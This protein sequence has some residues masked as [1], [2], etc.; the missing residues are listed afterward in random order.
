MLER[1]DGHAT[2]IVLPFSIQVNIAVMLVTEIQIEGTSL[3]AGLPRYDASVS[4]RLAAVRVTAAQLP[5][6]VQIAQSIHQRQRLPEMQRSLSEAFDKQEMDVVWPLHTRLQLDLERIDLQM[7]TDS[8]TLGW[9]MSRMKLEQK[10]DAGGQS[11]FSGGI[12]CIGLWCG[13]G[14][15]DKDDDLLLTGARDGEDVAVAL[16][17]T[18]LFEL[19]RNEFDR[20]A[21]VEF[22]C[23]CDVRVPRIRVVKP[24]LADARACADVLGNL[25]APHSHVLSNIHSP[26]P[27]SETVHAGL[28]TTEL[29]LPR[30]TVT[31]SM[32]SDGLQ[33]CEPA[34]EPNAKLLLLAVTSVHLSQ[35]STQRSVTYQWKAAGVSID[36]DLP[37]EHT[38]DAALP[39]TFLRCADDGITAQ[40]DCVAP[41]EGELVVENIAATVGGL[42]ILV[43]NRLILECFE[44]AEQWQAAVAAAPARTDA[45]AE[46]L[47][48]QRQRMDK[49]QPAEPPE[50]ETEPSAFAIP[51]LD[52]VF[53]EF[54]IVVPSTN[55]TCGLTLDAGDVR[56]SCGPS[57]DA[58][59]RGVV[60]VS[61]LHV[62]VTQ[63]TGTANLLEQSTTFSVSVAFTQ[64]PDRQPGVRGLKLATL[65]YNISAVDV[66]CSRSKAADIAA[67]VEFVAENEIVRRI[68]ANEKKVEFDVEVSCPS[69]SI[70][71]PDDTGGKALVLN[72][73]AARLA[74]DEPHG[75]TTAKVSTIEASCRVGGED[76]V[77]FLRLETVG[78]A[79]DAAV[80]RFVDGEAARLGV[81]L[82]HLEL[83]TSPELAQALLVPYKSSSDADELAQPDDNSPQG[84]DFVLTQDDII[85]ADMTV[86]PTQRLFVRAKPGEV[87]VLQGNGFS[88]RFDNTESCVLV[89]VSAGA[90]LMLSDTVLENWDPARVHLGAGARICGVV[91]MIDD[92]PAPSPRFVPTDLMSRIRTGS[93][94]VRERTPSPPPR[95]HDDKDPAP[96]AGSVATAAPGLI[97]VDLVLASCR[98]SF[99]ASSNRFDDPPSPATVRPGHQRA[100]SAD[101]G[102][103]AN[104]GV[105]RRRTSSDGGPGRVNTPP[106]GHR[107]TPSNVR[108]SYS[109][110][111]CARLKLSLK[112]Q[113][114]GGTLSAFCDGCSFSVSS[115][116]DGNTV[117][118]T[119]VTE[120]IV[121]VLQGSVDAKQISVQCEF[122]PITIRVTS[123]A[124]SRVGYVW[125]ALT[126]V[127]QAIAE[128]KPSAESRVA[129]SEGD[130]NDDLLRVATVSIPSVALELV[131]AGSV[132]FVRGELINIYSQ[133]TFAYPTLDMSLRVVTSCGCFN[134]MLSEWEPVLEK[135]HLAVAAKHTD[136]RDAESRKM[137]VSVQSSNGI[138]FN[139]TK[140][141]MHMLT[142]ILIPWQN[143]VRTRD[144]DGLAL[145][146]QETSHTIRNDT[147]WAV[148]MRLPSSHG[149]VEYSLGP[150]ETLEYDGAYMVEGGPSRRFWIQCDGCSGTVS[151]DRPGVSHMLLVSDDGQHQ[152]HIGMHVE[153]TG[154]T[155]KRVYIRSEVFVQNTT[156]A[157]FV[158]KLGRGTDSLVV[159]EAFSNATFATQD[160]IA[161]SPCAS[162]GKPTHGWARVFDAQAHND[163]TGFVTDRVMQ[164]GCIPLTASEKDARG[165]PT[166]TTEQEVTLLWHCEE[167]SLSSG[168]S[169]FRI[170]PPLVVQNR[171][172]CQLKCNLLAKRFDAVEL[173]VE[174]QLCNRTLEP[175]VDISLLYPSSVLMRV[176]VNNFEQSLDYPV[177]EPCTVEIADSDGQEIT[178]EMDSRLTDDG[179]WV[180]TL[181]ATTWIVNYT[182]LPLRYSHKSTPQGALLLP[183]T[184]EHGVISQRPTICDV[185]TMRVS[186]VGELNM[187]SSHSFDTAW[188]QSFNLTSVGTT[189]AVSIHDNNRSD[190]S[191]QH[192]YDL[193]VSIRFGNGR[194][195]RTRIV[196]LSAQYQLLNHL[197]HPLFYVQ[198]DKHALRADGMGV[199]VQPH[200]ST[201]V[202]WRNA[203]GKKEL[204]L[205]AGATDAQRWSAAI[206]VDSAFNLALAV[207][208]FDVGEAIVRLDCQEPGTSG[209]QVLL[210]R[211]F[212]RERTGYLVENHTSYNLCL[213]QY[214]LRVPPGQRLRTLLVEPHRAEPFVWEQPLRQHVAT[215]EIVSDTNKMQVNASFDNFVESEPVLW[216][217]ANV[218]IVSRVRV[219]GGT[220]VLRISTRPVHAPAGPGSPVPE[221]RGRMRRSRSAFSKQSRPLHVG[222]ELTLPLLHVAVVDRRPGPSELLA[223]CLSKCELN[224]DGRL[225]LDVSLHASV[226]AIQ[227]EDASASA[228]FPVVFGARDVSSET[229]FL[230]VALTKSLGDITAHNYPYISLLMQSAILTVD[231]KFLARAVGYF[232]D[233]AIF[234]D[235]QQQVTQ[236]P[237]AAPQ[238]QESGV[239]WDAD[240]SMDKF[241]TDGT[242]L[243]DVRPFYCRLLEL[244][245][246]HIIVT[247]VTTGAARELLPVLSDVEGADLQ[248]LPIT[249][250]NTHTTPQRF[251][252]SLKVRYR[253]QLSHEFY[254]ML[255]TSDLL[256]NPIGL[257]ASLGDGVRA[258][259]Y[260]PASAV[261]R[262][263]ADISIED[264]AGG[265]AKGMGALL[266]SSIHAPMNSVSKVTGSVSKSV[267]ILSG[268]DKYISDRSNSDRRE[269]MRKGHLGHGLRA[270]AEGLAK[271]LTTGIG[272][273]VKAPAQAVQKEG[274]WGLGKGVRKGLAGAVVKPAVGAMDLAEGLTTGIRNTATLLH[275]AAGQGAGERVRL[276]PPRPPTDAADGDAP[277]QPYDAGLAIG[278]AALDAGESLVAHSRNE[279]GS[280]ILTDARVLIVNRSASAA[281]AVDCPPIAMKLSTVTSVTRTT[282]GEGGAP[283]EGDA[284]GGVVPGLLLQAKAPAEPLFVPLGDEEAVDEFVGL[285][286]VQIATRAR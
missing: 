196:A 102:Q 225:G 26:T 99:V 17:L 83:I 12:G 13:N 240:G 152:R 19:S 166:D 5:V 275:T 155:T 187:F 278:F 165:M 181:Y 27:A 107:R 227:L 9:E 274:V 210:V 194:Y 73:A 115:I 251:L 113:S 53:N 25:L 44:H 247:V 151:L 254:M 157:S 162:D 111:V 257:I 154:A 47:L 69:V 250:Q 280:V 243:Q 174:E 224:A 105:A 213:W 191:P 262:H 60:S 51:T 232:E 179:C 231:D 249:A 201:P 57:P 228:A 244:H 270:G 55:P 171:L 42:A 147:R 120:P 180:V 139:V 168:P 163:R 46:A 54:Q 183:G 203:N 66:I 209:S 146:A 39:N 62:F 177:D 101:V 21:R 61:D 143:A 31:V 41:R 76:T 199:A 164:I 150:G 94:S 132:A 91:T 140:N 37:L 74:V 217:A 43:S 182:G 285:I 160:A 109:L 4:A 259:F 141:A 79:S 130:A 218:V 265:F 106:R 14:D 63:P 281:P 75:E 103:F 215:V 173:F 135:S 129:H 222:F 56:V 149:E 49:L 34:V 156:A 153:Q 263:P 81:E 148:S 221:L 226:A 158:L 104:F 248:L 223:L 264:V 2:D 30:L 252:Q 125:L 258:F 92:S 241:S 80:I 216:S 175:G 159:I 95:L 33:D 260:E 167:S 96:G 255:G 284:A 233:E 161:I 204:F 267:A 78:G 35:S 50:A 128:L 1:R 137:E 18:N 7:R 256:G 214:G 86:G 28:H 169:C 97:A 276:R 189:G 136:D 235:A 70:T 110:D 71:L 16:S 142:N 239:V 23:P 68:R 207:P 89:F 246:V 205:R 245:P 282:S 114:E 185:E 219:R 121:V 59:A 127:L 266:H 8:T 52:L 40:V 118:S 193:V 172:P 108:R 6:V 253:Q 238:D 144:P 93:K 82:G 58:L 271:G 90:T 116:V 77:E 268:D 117:L 283:A 72:V 3:T 192:R 190:G 112:P 38:I 208:A 236:A 64:Q 124:F 36:T 10:S 85:T 32:E 202:Y 126:D 242:E 286:S 206:A 229:P 11:W 269:K 134:S 230:Q 186:V 200:V 198:A 212:E 65:G 29:L 100:R 272:G 211:P 24:F 133:V 261:F 48:A 195:K 22:S 145:V 188:S 45:T 20:S 131:D 84:A 176:E 87:V 197:E 123:E 237:G 277:L 184:Y 273:L 119:K 98:V 178:L 220:K 234:G 67:V 279:S 170:E 122:E 138:M 15:D 88:L